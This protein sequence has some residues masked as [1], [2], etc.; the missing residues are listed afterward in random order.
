[1]NFNIFSSLYCLCY[2]SN[3]RCLSL[4]HLFSCLWNAINVI[5]HLLHSLEITTLRK[6]WLFFGISKLLTNQSLVFKGIFSVSFYM[7]QKMKEDFSVVWVLHT[8]DCPTATMRMSYRQNAHLPCPS[9]TTVDVLFCTTIQ[10]KINES[11]LKAHDHAL[12][13]TPLFLAPNGWVPSPVLTTSP[14]TKAWD[15]QG[16]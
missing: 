16:S 4:R 14:T 9:C 10:A 6:L 1:M 13:T 15:K 8:T 7:H 2:Y 3:W 5:I 11:R 12:C